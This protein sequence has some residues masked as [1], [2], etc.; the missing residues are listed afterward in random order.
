MFREASAVK[1]TRSIPVAVR[2][3]GFLI[4]AQAAAASDLCWSQDGV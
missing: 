1:V 3:L 2:Y 4:V